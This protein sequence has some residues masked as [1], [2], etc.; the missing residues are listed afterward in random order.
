MTPSKYLK[1]QKA[2]KTARSLR[3]KT[4]LT[5]MMMR[6]ACIRMA[7]K[8]VRKTKKEKIPM[9]TFIKKAVRTLNQRALKTRR[10]RQLR[11]ARSHPRLKDKTTIQGTRDSSP[12]TIPKGNSA[13]KDT[14]TAF[15]MQAIA[16]MRVRML[17]LFLNLQ[18]MN[19]RKQAC[20]LPR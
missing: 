9:M 3:L 4:A 6:R 15:K 7:L 8:V 5:K 13:P 1:F 17:V 14:S 11:T 16:K 20:Q 10:A 12:G 18:P 2:R 19:L